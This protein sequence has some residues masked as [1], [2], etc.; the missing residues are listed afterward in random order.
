MFIAAIIALLP[1]APLLAGEFVDTFPNDCEQLTAGAHRLTGT[2]ECDAA[3][4]HVRR[5]LEEIGVDELIVQP[6]PTAQTRVRQCQLLVDGSAEPITLLPMRPNGIIPPVT[7]PEGIAGPLVYIGDG[8]GQALASLPG[9]LLQGAIAVADYNSGRGWMRAFRLGAA[10]VIFVQN[11]PAEAWHPHFADVNVNL[12][13]YYL[14]GGLEALPQL[15]AAK[16]LRAAIHSRITW[17]PVVGRNVFGFLRGTDPTFEQDKEEML[18]LAAPLDTFGEVPRLSP[19]ARRAANCA[20]LLELAFRFKMQRPRRHV[21]FAFL[22]A[23]SRGHTGSSVLHRALETDGGVQ[24]EKRRQSWEAE[25]TFLENMAEMLAADDPFR[26]EAHNDVRKEFLKRLRQKA[27]EHSFAIGR[28]LDLLRR[29]AQRSPSSDAET[30]AAIEQLMHEKDRWNSARR[31]L[32]RDRGYDNAS[33]CAQQLQTILD[34]LA[35]DVRM[36][37][38]ELEIEQRALEADEQLEELVGD[39]WTTLHISL[40]L[41]DTTPRW[42]LVIGGD[43]GLHSQNDKTGLYGKIQ[44][45]F[46]RAWK[47]MDLLGAAPPNFEIGSADQTI[48]DTRMLFAAPYFVH[49]GEAAGRLGIYNLALATCQEAMPREGTPDDTLE[50]LDIGRI[51]QQVDEIGGLLFS[52]A[53]QAVNW[54]EKVVLREVRQTGGESPSG[55]ADQDSLSLR[56]MIV[57]FKQ[58]GMPSFSDGSVSG[59]RVMGTMAGSAMRHT[60][61]PGAVVQFWAPLPRSISYD[62]IKPYG[63]DNFQVLITDRNGSYV[64]GP[65]SPHWDIFYGG[66]AATFDEQGAVVSASN[67]DSL[68]RLRQR[69]DVLACRSG[70]LILPPQEDESIR[71]A[72]STRVFDAD[73]NAALENSKTFTHLGD[74]VLQWYCDE[75]VERVKVFGI[76][77]VAALNIGSE[78]PYG[79]GFPAATRPMG[80]MAQ[81]SAEDLWRLNELR[82]DI[83]RRKDIADSSLS[84]LHGRSE[85]LLSAAADAAGPL[86]REAMAAGSYLASKPVYGS[87]RAKL[88]DLVFGVLILLGLSVPFAFAVERVVVGAATIYRRIAWGAVFFA[89]TFILLY[90]SHPAF[91]VA[92]TPV[93]IFLGFAIVVMATLVIIII[94]RKFEFELKVLQGQTAGTHVAGVSKVGT[95]LAAMQMGISTMRRR[96]LRTMLTAVTIILLTYTILCFASF[97]TQ[98]GIVKVF[99][100]PN[101]DHA[102]AFVHDVNWQPLA[103]DLPDILAGRWGDRAAICQR[104]WICPRQQSDPG[105]L[106][107]LGDGSNPTAVKGLLGISD[108]ELRQRPDLAAV[109]GGSLD[110]RVLFTEA[111]ARNLGAAPGDTVIVQGV[112]L[113]VGVVPDAPTFSAASDMDGSRVLPVDFTDVTSSRQPTTASV[114]A[115]ETRLNW[116][117]LPADSVAVV[118]AGTAERLGAQLYGVTI[119]TSDAAAATALAEDMARMLPLPVAATRANGVYL[120]LL[121]TVIAAS[122]SKDLVFPIALGG[123]VIFGTMLGSVTDRERE[124]YAFSAVG[125]APR[126]VATLFFAESLIYSLIGG[127]GGYLIAQGAGK[128][129]SVLAGYG[130]VRVPEMNM[131]STNT[132]VTILIVMA[133]VM[134]SAIYPAI[135]ASKSANPGLM[136]IWRPPKPEGD[137]MDLVF[138]F[139]VSAYD[140]TGVVSFLKEH[141]DN[142]SDTGL[143]KFMARGTQLVRLDDGALGLTSRVSLS[144]FDLGVSQE[145]ALRSTPSEI[146]GIDEVKIHLQRISGQPKDW[147]RLNKLFLDELRRQFLFWRSLPHET[148][149]S[150]RRQT[151][152]ANDA[153]DDS[154]G[155]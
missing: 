10:A 152:D 128:V 40:L 123:L 24:V 116:S 48:A 51:R 19:G 46:L 150:Y 103:A 131:S 74:G 110:G 4:E 5:Q 71:L 135:K 7:P 35:E 92:N 99:A 95:F 33:E 16:P 80:A 64:F 120:H 22:G 127:M 146:P 141:F 140:I 133:T 47:A 88:D 68:K 134:V 98:T 82:M 3:A 56:R 36:R 25:T 121:G 27:A 119:Y 73:T 101:P 63:F 102:G 29:G 113:R 139:T 66:F 55:V 14:P 136:R 104:R 126:H 144:P 2:P 108:A 142:Y 93:V 153:A 78:N 49:S 26:S 77:H 53:E 129:L 118:S 28:R 122:G 90:L 72:Q 94:M 13:R 61:V 62:T 31:I 151:L 30:S 106:L 60:P 83:L 155:V 130:L 96:P 70:A 148:M 54:N 91:S 18:I 57:P 41:G 114:E 117:T 137:I 12:P 87:I 8:S 86:R 109:L 17:E 75:R 52:F 97:G 132:I 85:D 1:A 143:G 125:L 65:V 111:M 89:A 145:F 38:A 154:S 138:P 9:A 107:T 15:G 34:E 115:I 58:Y 100:E 32:G 67:N 112:P 23:E 84:E 43:S 20:G 105:I 149:E 79:D 50:N 21:L 76:G 6:F 11:E 44:A 69:L 59:P 124:I 81:R 147:R 39:Y 37:R 45:A 42:G